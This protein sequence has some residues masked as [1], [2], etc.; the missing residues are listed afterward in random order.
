M[1]T[2]WR[3][4]P[5]LKGPNQ[6]VNARK[7]LLA[8]D[9]YLDLQQTFVIRIADDLPSETPVPTFDLVVAFFSRSPTHD[10]SFRIAIEKRKDDLDRENFF[11]VAKDALH[12]NR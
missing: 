3:P 4:F 2:F 6:P 11:D 9:R 7:I 12:A 5:V 8:I 10:S 1:L